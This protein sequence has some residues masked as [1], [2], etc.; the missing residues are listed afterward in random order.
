[1]PTVF[2]SPAA[3]IVRFVPEIEGVGELIGVTVM[4]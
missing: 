1:V 4:G 2:R 3:G